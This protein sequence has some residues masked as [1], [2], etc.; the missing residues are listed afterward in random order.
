MQKIEIQSEF[1]KE[2]GKGIARQLRMRGKIPAV[3]Y[4]AGASTLLTMD[5]KDIDKV[6][7]SA[8]GENTLITLQI[9]GGAG[10][11]SRV[12]ILRDFQRDPITGKVLHADLFEINM[13]EP[14]VIKVP[15]EVVGAVSVGVK[16]GGVLQHNLR[17]LEIRCL[18]SLIP[19]HIQVDASALAIGESVHAK[20][21]RLAE[22]IE[23]MTDPDQ[24]V[25]SVAAPISEAKLEEL[26]TAPKEVKEP[27]VLTKKEGEE[28]PKA[29]GERERPK[30]GGEA[31]AKP[32]A[33]GKEEKKETKK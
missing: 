20:D 26:L 13:N 15:V 27:E 11:A 25:V 1:R 8:S 9:S 4:G 18:P 21:I 33:K 3:L 32:E 28:A 23:V 19:D 17:E 7:H 10:E 22:G 14:I 16:E 5:P 12:A 29:E 6:L 24:V 2:A 31:K 30:A